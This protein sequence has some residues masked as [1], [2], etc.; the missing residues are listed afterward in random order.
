[1]QVL[2]IEPNF[3]G[4]VAKLALQAL[5]LKV[6]LCVSGCACACVW[7]VCVWGGYLLTSLDEGIQEHWLHIWQRQDLWEF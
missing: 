3:S 6:Y 5:N 7:C 1:M 2:V 4:R